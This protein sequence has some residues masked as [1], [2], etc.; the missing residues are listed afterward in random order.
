MRAVLQNQAFR[1][2]WIAQVVLALGDAVMQMGLLEFFRAHG[3]NERVE[4]AKLFFAVSLPGLLLGPVAMAYLDRW[5]RRN[6]LMVSDSFRALIVGVIAVW[7]VPVLTG[8]VEERDLFMVYV[9]IFALGAITTFYYPARYALLPN[10]VASE[11]LIQANTLFTTTLAVAS[12]GGRALGGFVAER[13]GVEWAVLANVLAYLAS[14]ALV[15]GIRMNPHATSGGANAQPGGGW[16]ELKSGLV[17]LWQHPSA[18]PLVIL[19]AVFAFLGGILLIAMIGYGLD[20]LGLRT[21]GLGY[22]MTAAGAG[23]ALG[24]VAVG[25]AKAWTRAGWLPFV[26]LIIGGGLLKLLSLTTNPWVAAGLLIPLGA[27]VATAFIVIDAKLQEQVD[28]QRR[29]AVFAARGMLTSATMV[30]AFWLQFGTETFRRTPAP[31]ILEW[32]GVGSVVAAVLTLLAMRL[33]RGASA[34]A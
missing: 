23:A 13:M 3:Y 19:A 25:R 7:L 17:Y 33:K 28:D 10:L 9:M 8:R 18:L 29:G 26:Q 34:T 27:I 4:T 31:V 5:Q 11:N 32:L 2:L 24:V 15:W 6:V 16:G 14:I 30:V 1:K 20:T 22:L 12:V 21:G